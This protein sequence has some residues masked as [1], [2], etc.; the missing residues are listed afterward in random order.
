MVSNLSE[1]GHQQVDML[2]FVVLADAV[3]SVFSLF[4]NSA[5]SALASMRQM[6]E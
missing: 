6:I 3:F 5:R 2:I 4:T 1:K